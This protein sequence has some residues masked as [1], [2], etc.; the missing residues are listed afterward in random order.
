MRIPHTELT[1]L[2]TDFFSLFPFKDRDCATRPLVA[3]FLNNVI[4]FC[5]LSP[6]FP[7]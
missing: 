3:S 1:I 7:K 5:N 6:S 4:Q 2:N